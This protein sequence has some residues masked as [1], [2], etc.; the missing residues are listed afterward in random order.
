MPTYLHLLADN[1]VDVSLLAKKN[2]SKL[3]PQ[4]LVNSGHMWSYVPI[5]KWYIFLRKG[6][7]KAT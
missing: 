6:S 7:G 5:C 4:Y 2:K 1:I 3:R